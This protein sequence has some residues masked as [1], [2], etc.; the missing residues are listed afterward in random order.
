MTAPSH[1]P[2][3]VCND[4][5]MKYFS[6][7]RVKKFNV[8]L[9]VPSSDEERWIPINFD[10]MMSELSGQ[11]V[12][13]QSVKVISDHHCPFI[14]RWRKNDLINRGVTLMND[15]KVGSIHGFSGI[16]ECSNTNTWNASDIPPILYHNA[17]EFYLTDLQV[18]YIKLME[19]MADKNGLLGRCCSIRN[20]RT[21]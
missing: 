11:S 5:M 21:F 15:K 8:A 10:G 14:V 19:C 7:C 9:V 2:S 18:A 20:R 13:F 12:A 4:I 17:H 6:Q 1:L 3:A 16:G